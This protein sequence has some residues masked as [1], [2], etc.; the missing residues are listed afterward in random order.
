MTTGRYTVVSRHTRQRI[1]AA[2]RFEENFDEDWL[3]EAQA[4]AGRPALDLRVNTLKATRDKVLK[5]LDRSGVEPAAIARNGIRV[6]AGE[7]ASRL[8]NVTAEISFEK[9][10][11]EV[12]DEGSQIVADL[13]MPKENDQIL[14][15]CAGGG[16]TSSPWPGRPVSR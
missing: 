8:P 6:K 11:F 1:A 4:L 9:G 13:V 10:W 16:G 5:A 3:E 7:G 2:S 15:Y 12:Q 14:D